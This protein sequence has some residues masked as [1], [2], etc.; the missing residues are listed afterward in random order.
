MSLTPKRP[1][2]PTT[3]KPVLGSITWFPSMIRFFETFCEHVPQN[4]LHRS[5]YFKK[6]GP[7]DQ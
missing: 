7:T 6:F 2:V 3:D 4:K 5:K 1:L